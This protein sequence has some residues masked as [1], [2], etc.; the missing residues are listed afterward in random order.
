MLQYYLEKE[1]L[2]LIVMQLYWLKT[3][4]VGFI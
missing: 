3:S 2:F 1:L 4:H